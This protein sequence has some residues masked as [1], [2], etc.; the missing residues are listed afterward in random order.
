M[1]EILHSC[2]TNVRSSRHAKT[3]SR[4][5]TM[6]FSRG[7]FRR[8]RPSD[9]S[10]DELKRAARDRHYYIFG[11]NTF[12]EYFLGGDGKPRRRIAFH[13]EEIRQMRGTKG[14][15][16]RQPLR[17]RRAENSPKVPLITDGKATIVRT[18][19]TR[20]FPRPFEDYGSYVIC[21]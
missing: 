3:R 4:R 1:R 13:A 16:P 7:P 19:E 18:C 10:R 20:V 15:I 21:V 2:L 8:I 9:W 6:C 14:K 17:R 12:A 11:Y 5:K